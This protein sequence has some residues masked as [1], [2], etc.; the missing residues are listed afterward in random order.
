[1][2]LSFLDFLK[3]LQL[4]FVSKKTCCCLL[5]LTI[6]S[7]SASFAANTEHVAELRQLVQLAEY[8]SVDYPAAVENGQVIN[9]G[10]HQ[11]MVEFS[12]LILNKSLHFA[13]SID[14]S[15]ILADQAKLLQVAIINKQPAAMVQTLASELRHSLLVLAPQASVPESL[16][17]K[18]DSQ[19]LFIQNCAGCHGETGQGNGALAA[20][21]A[22]PPTNFMD[23]ERASNRS[24]L[25]LYDAI[26]NGIEGTAMTAFGHLT[27]KQKWSLAFYTG[28]LAFQSAT[29]PQQQI[30][31]V[32]S[33]QQ[34]I[35]YSP[36]LLSKELPA[37]QR[38]QIGILRANPQPLF[39]TDTNPISITRH[40]LEAAV[41][42][43]QNGR[44]SQAH[45]LAVSAYLDGFEQ[46]EVSLSAKDDEIK[47][48]LESLLI[49]LRQ[50]FSRGENDVELN[51]VLP[52]IF[53]K[54][55]QAENILTETSLSSGELFS[56][57]LIIL[58]REGL[59]ALLVVIALTTV[60]LRTNR[61][62]ALKYLHFGWIS[63]LLAGAATW[64]AAQT[65]ISISGTSREIMEGVGALLAAIVLFYV[66]FWMHSKSHAAH[67]QAYIQ[68][69]V[70]AHL[71]TGT[72]WGLAALSF[73]AVYREIFETVLFY[74]S[75]LTQAD[76]STY[77]SV[78]SGFL[79]AVGLLSVLTW[80]LIRYSIK[81]PITQFFASTTYLLLALAFVLMGKAISALQE[82]AVVGISP[83]PVNFQVEWLGI[84]ATWQGV[85]AQGLILL[86]SVALTMGSKLRRKSYENS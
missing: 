38:N 4:F 34:L 80:V 1:M 72:L 15:G 11:E 82:A 59:E 74:Q 78:I 7:S 30:E 86:L 76:A 47:D 61:K 63:A 73:V 32:L 13:E 17:S 24:V 77:S 36:N 19:K 45:D 81:L 9:A 37:E 51:K 54:L 16:M 85:L 84:Y 83:F 69:Q 64:V 5:L 70:D 40:Q 39:V 75:L 18:A 66:G 52:I 65:L 29:T 23:K 53:Q 25:G 27:E 2:T 31:P 3:H 71:K 62:D 43:Y 22:P 10:E 55:S 41:D 12:G 50:L 57:S 44:Y 49:S 42:A 67:W 21:L 6:L 60:L 28:S 26:T 56:A 14:Q 48:E 33:L 58:L 35:N 79:V 20:E 68:K 46:V 8:I